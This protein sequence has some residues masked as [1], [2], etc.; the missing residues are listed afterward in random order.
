M[1]LMNVDRKIHDPNL[2]VPDSC[3][4]GST[5]GSQG[6]TLREREREAKPL[7]QGNPGGAASE[8]ERS[9]TMVPS[10]QLP[11]RKLSG[12]M[13]LTLRPPNTV[14]ST[15]GFSHLIR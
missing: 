4:L 10:E 13:F 15:I 11:H 8:F 2:P 7:P 1:W 6:L 14:I 9:K 3:G 12:A 5:Q